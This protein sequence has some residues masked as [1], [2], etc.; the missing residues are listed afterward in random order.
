MD[1][2]L[3]AFPVDENTSG[4]RNRDKI[5]I[6]ICYVFKSLAQPIA[7]DVIL[8]ALYDNGIANYFEISQAVYELEKN[9]AIALKDG[10]DAE[11]V[12]T[13]NGRKIADDLE[14]E[15]SMYIRHKATQAAMKTLV[16]KKRLRENKVSIVNLGGEKYRVDITIYSGLEGEGENDSLLDVSMYV[17][18]IIQAEVIKRS[19]LNNPSKLYENVA[20]ALTEDVDFVD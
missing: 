20:Q 5:K 2:K 9:G 3:D 11:Y 15:L 8:S 4:L 7:K 16:Y 19:F 6:L 10:D 17:P 14:R 12:L 1:F 18:D 13:E